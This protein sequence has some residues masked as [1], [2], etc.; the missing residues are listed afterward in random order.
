MKFKKIVIDCN[1]LYYRN[2]FV[3]KEYESTVAGK[4]I[5]TGGV[6]GFLKS[7]NVIERTL[8]LPGGSIYFLWDNPTSKDKLRKQ[9][10]EEY[11]DR[12]EI[13]PN[14]KL[15][16]NKQSD[17][18]YRGIDYLRILL[19]N[20][21]DNYYDI[22]VPGYE[23]DDIVKP[24]I[25]AIDKYETVLVH[26]EDLDWARSMDRNVFWYAKNKIWNFDSF[27]KKYG[28]FPTG[29]TVA[30]YKAIRGD[31]SDHIPIGIPHLSEKIVL[32]IVN[33]FEDIYDFFER[34]ALKD[35]L[36][37]KWKEKIKKCKSRLR[38]NYQL[39]DFIKIS[40]EL[41]DEN[42]ILCYNNYNKYRQVL[43]ILGFNEE[44]YLSNKPQPQYLKSEGLFKQPKSRR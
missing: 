19:Q 24:V 30:I 20:R 22:Q 2:Y 27:K 4:Q 6:H 29:N 5:K 21:N 13:D 34:Y 3:F 9:M 11:E 33:D 23:A 26:S 36:S 35:Y 25:Q 40:K 43:R 12:K 7:L 44:Q 10:D 39:V 16:R 15:L 17:A 14:Y 8:L 37:D 38:L 28:F 18:F 1:N 31:K 41:V 32:K 42:T